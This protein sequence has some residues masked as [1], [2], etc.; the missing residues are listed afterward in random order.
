MQS[1]TQGTGAFDNSNVPSRTTIHEFDENLEV[2]GKRSVDTDSIIIPAYSLPDDLAGFRIA[3]GGR[4]RFIEQIEIGWFDYEENPD[5]ALANKS[6]WY[7]QFLVG[8]QTTNENQYEAAWEIFR[9]GEV[10]HLTQALGLSSWGFGQGIAWRRG[11]ELFV[12]ELDG[13]DYPQ[14]CVHV[15]V[16]KDDTFRTCWDIA[17][18]IEEFVATRLEPLIRS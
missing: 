8:L 15:S 17:F 3:I 7:I 12:V 5:Y 18:A 2:C 10:E 14:W 9:K 1:L 11:Q 4:F 6:L 13:F 16:A